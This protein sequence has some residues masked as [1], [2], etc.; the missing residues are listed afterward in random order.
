MEPWK[1]TV[2]ICCFATFIV[3]VG[4]G[5]VAPM[6]PIFV[7]ELGIGDQSEISRW[8][9]I[10]FGLNFVT[11][12]V[13]A[14]IWGRLSDKYGRRPMVLRASLWLS[15]IMI[16]MGF[17]RD[18]YD[19]AV[20]RFL[21]GAM[22]GFLG[23]IIPLVAQETPSS[24]SGWAL[25]IFYTCQVGGALI[26]PLIG[27]Y[28]AEIYSCRMTFI[29]VG[30]FC[31]LGFLASF[32]IKE[33]VKPKGVQKLPSIGECFLS[34]PRPRLILG[35]YATNFLLQFTLMSSHPII[36]LYI[37]ELI[38][39]TEHL[40]LISGAVFSV[41]GFASMVAAS[42]LG[43]I[44]DKIGPDRV[45]VASLIVAGLFSLP[46][47]FVE[48]PWQLGLLRF[49]LGASVAGLLPSINSLIRRNTP[50][51]SLGRVYG[52]NQSAQF[53]GMFSGSLAGGF[54]ASNFGIPAIL[55]CSGLMLLT[56]AALFKL[57]L[58]RD[59]GD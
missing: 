31:F 32:G 59:I 19:L 33:T 27:G 8:S 6:L 13:A 37:K 14:P 4:M 2:Y 45:L 55:F 1:K 12:A 35:L 58:K 15:I 9:G 48:N 34:L 39:E 57:C 5:Q 44:S 28:I 11:L 38:P 46:Q 50:E 47:A 41:A 26:G 42:P 49:V 53:V 25:G 21:Q 30:V 17:A 51:G 40:A 56:N 18:V 7:A 36:T 20:L 24:Q 10:I 16:G 22:S 29:V 54:A 52:L 23:A 3:S 43:R